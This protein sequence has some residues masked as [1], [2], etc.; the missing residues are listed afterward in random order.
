MLLSPAARAVIADSGG[1]HQLTVEVIDDAEGLRQSRAAWQSI[2]A[3]ATAAT[4]FSSWEWLY[5]WWQCYAQPGD[6]PLL[7]LCHDGA[8]PVALAPLQIQRRGPLGL[9]RELRFLGS[10]EAEHE[11]VL[12]EYLDLLCV[13]GEEARSLQA[14]GDTLR[15]LRGRWHCALFNDL[16]PQ[17]LLPQLL[18]RGMPAASTQRWQR[19]AR[20]RVD[21]PPNYDTWLDGLSRAMRYRIRRGQRRLQAAGELSCERATTAQQISAQLPVLADLHRQRWGSGGLFDQPRFARFHPLV[22]QRMFESGASRPQLELMRLDG[23]P[24]TALYSFRRGATL[25]YYQSGFCSEQARCSPLVL[26]HAAAI[27]GAIS[28]GLRHYDLM[29][30]G[31]D[32]YKASYAAAQTPMHYLARYPQPAL[33]QRHLPEPLRDSL[34][35]LQHRLARRLLRHRPGAEAEQRDV[36]LAPPADGGVGA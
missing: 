18:E 16:L 2:D 8:R 6:S 20:Y 17:A 1:M 23:A 9:A 35:G 26:A 25:H 10:G 34:G 22:C 30:G 28:D 33:L 31:L 24:L 7:L 32:S 27:R 29:R 5:S 19:G 15:R 3:T 11:E 4:P 36:R 21:L 13:P 14:I 12:S